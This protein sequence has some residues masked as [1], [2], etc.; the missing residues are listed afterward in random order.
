MSINTVTSTR[1]Y[2]KIVR[3]EKELQRLKKE[4]YAVIPQKLRNAS[5]YQEEALISAVRETRDAIWRERYGKKIARI[6]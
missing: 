1:I 3:L 2:N 5:H 6:R 4:A